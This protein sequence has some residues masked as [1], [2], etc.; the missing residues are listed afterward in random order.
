MPKDS[1]ILVRDVMSTDVTT[2]LEDEVL[3]DATLVLARAGLRHIPVMNGE[4]LVG[5]ITST[6]VKHY[7]PSILS[8]IPA[9]EY[10]RL[11]ATTPISKI[12]TRNPITIEPDQTVFEAAGLLLDRRIGCL[13]VVE[14]GTLKGI[15]TTTDMLKVL[16]QLMRDLGFVPPGLTT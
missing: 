9:E 10:N 2:L 8:G 15:I 3:L 11:M 5:V 6:D 14:N 4:R 7:T 16:L 13:P 1:P 12:M